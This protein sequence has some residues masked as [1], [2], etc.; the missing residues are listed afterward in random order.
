[1]PTGLREIVMNIINFH[2]LTSY[3]LN[4]RIGSLIDNKKQ[5]LVAGLLLISPFVIYSH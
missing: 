3:S 2:L 4:D 1:M 5:M